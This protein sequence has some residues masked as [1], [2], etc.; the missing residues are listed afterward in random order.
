MHRCGSTV[1]DVRGWGMLKAAGVPFSVAIFI[2]DEF[3]DAVAK[4]IN[5]ITR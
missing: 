4:L 5:D 2:Q 1:A 3:G